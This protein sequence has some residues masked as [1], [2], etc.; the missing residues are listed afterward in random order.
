V[1]GDE[2]LAVISRFLGHSNLSTTA[3]ADA[4]LTPAM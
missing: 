4:H 3:D 2:E 1:P